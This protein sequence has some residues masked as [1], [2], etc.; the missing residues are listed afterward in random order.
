MK[1]TEEKINL[2]VREK[3][4]ERVGNYITNKTNLSANFFTMIG[5]L[6][7][8]VAF[9]IIV[10]VGLFWGAFAVLISSLFDALD[11]AIA[12]S[13][14]ACSYFGAFFD[15]VADRLGE[16][17]YFS[18]IFLVY[19][20]FSIFLAATTSLLVSYLNASA[21]ARNFAPL[22]GKIIGRPG[23]IILLFILM[24]LNNWF[25]IY[26]TIWLI[27]VLNIIT[28]FKRFFEIKKQSG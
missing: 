12:K 6:A 9:L 7:S 3:I 14:K 27:V 18:A 21:R 19:N 13:R 28:L 10:N 24:L 26:L 25:P 2:F 4:N 1:I 15:D 11:G 5:V 16:I 17:F 23:R 22:T 20:Y 8:F